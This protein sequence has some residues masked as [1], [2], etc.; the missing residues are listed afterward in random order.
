MYNTRS[1][2]MMME[3]ETSATSHTSASLL[4]DRP[5]MV[6]SNILLEPSTGDSQATMSDHHGPCYAL[7]ERTIKPRDFNGET[8]WRSYQN[9]YNRIADINGWS[10]ETRKKHLWINLSGTALDYVDQL[11]EERTHTYE[12]MC[13]ALDLRFG[14]ECLS[15]IFRAELDHCVR[16]PEESI[17]ALGQEIWRLTRLAYPD[18]AMNAVREIAKEKF[19]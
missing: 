12:D 17:S 13:A 15:T 6:T 16:R 18:F 8:S 11:P 19:V 4:Q 7:R 14:S 1:K 5:I 2:K 9:Q 3:D 10:T